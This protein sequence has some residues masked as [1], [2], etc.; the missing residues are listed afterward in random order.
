MFERR[1]A[2][3]LEVC[4]KLGSKTLY[5]LK[6]RFDQISQDMVFAAYLPENTN[7]V[8]SRGGAFAPY[9]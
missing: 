6:W 8:L 1:T 4:S 2:N 5:C 7:L 3:G 9:F